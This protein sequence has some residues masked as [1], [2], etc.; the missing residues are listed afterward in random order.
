MAPS[1]PARGRSKADG[2][3]ASSGPD[4]LA[5]CRDLR[6]VYG[7]GSGQR[8]AV[9]GVNLDVSAGE[10]LLIWGPS[11]S[12]KSTLLGVLGGLDRDY[13]GTV[14]LFGEDAASLS[15]RQLARLRGERVGFV[16]QSFHLLG[17]LDVL[18]NV[19][20]ASWFGRDDASRRQRA[21]ELLEWVGLDDRRK[22]HPHELSG[23]Q[24]QRVAIARALL[25]EPELLFCDEPTGHLDRATGEQMIDLFADV[26]ERFNTTLVIVTHED[27]LRR[28]ATRSI[29]I[30][31]GRLTEGPP[32]ELET[33]PDPGGDSA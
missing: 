28:I 22:A 24:R 30:E 18:E 7:R 17:H 15:D 9:D 26:R 8:V 25:H 4:V 23:G 11:G 29:A 13:E 32:S 10:V 14:R 19:M 5:S 27:R 12:G 33:H 21:R 31:D 2:P 6:R 1:P 20:T 16:F 3:G